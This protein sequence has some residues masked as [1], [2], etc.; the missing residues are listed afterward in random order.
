MGHDE[1]CIK[2]NCDRWYTAKYWYVGG[3]YGGCTETAM[4]DALLKNGPLSVSFEV[5]ADFF[6]YK[7]GIYHHT[8]VK[9]FEPYVV[10]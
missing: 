7:T 10:S 4:I 6:H 2:E 8:G 9:G 1:K 5:Y 3:Y